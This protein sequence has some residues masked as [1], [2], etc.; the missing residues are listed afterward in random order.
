MAP[1]VPPVES[2]RWPYVIAGC[3]LAL[4]LISNAAGGYG[5]FRDE[6]YYLACTMRPDIG[7]VDHPPLSIWILTVSRAV[8]G[9]STFAVRLLPAIAGAATVLLAGLLTRRLGGGAAAQVLACFATAL[10]PVRLGISSIYSMN[11]FDI[12][13][14]TLAFLVLLDLIDEQRPRTWL[15]LGLL[16]GLGMLNKISAGWLAFGIALGMVATTR[17][18]WLR[19]PWPWAAAGI[20]AVVFLPF[21]LWNITHEFAHLEFARRA[22]EMKYT[23]QNP[24]TF[25]RELILSN[26][27]LSMPVWI[28]GIVYLLRT[29]RVRM[30][31]VA[32]LGVLAILFI[33]FHSKSEYFT[34]AMPLLFAAGSV[35]IGRMLERPGWRWVPAAYTPLLIATGILIVPMALDVL[36]PEEF[37]RYQAAFGLAPA[38]VEGHRLNGLPQ[39]YAD[40]FG[41]RELADS[42]AVAYRA[43]T[44]EEQRNCIVLAGNYGEAASIDILGKRLGLPGAISQHNSYYYWGFNEWRGQQVFIVIG[45]TAD[46][47]RGSFERME[48][49]GTTYARWAMPYEN[50]RTI[51]VCKGFKGPF[52]PAW[53]SGK[54]FI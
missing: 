2:R 5:L 24:A 18:R 23:S 6:L 1:D 36:P 31:G 50:G 45:R 40:R 11:V 26:N 44:P 8:L 15:L 7:Y 17:R 28:A 13:L 49:V 25:V 10:S 43:L 14:W 52:A 29:A 9:D 39:G 30:L 20:A 21:I 35:A 42:V 38:S 41:W 33:N 47:L 46:D 16:L 51:W 54:N 37:L 48:A 34:P 3:L 4:S 19:T 12:L 22:A 27:P 53:R 32:V